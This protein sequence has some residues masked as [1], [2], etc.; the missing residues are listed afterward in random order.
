MLR[1]IRL[2]GEV[3]D[4]RI[5]RSGRK[6]VGLRICQQG[7]QVNAPHDLTSAQI[8]AIVLGKTDWIL[9]KL[10]IWRNK[11]SQD[12]A[13]GF[14]PGTAVFPLLGDLWKPEITVNGQL[15][16]VPADSAEKK[17]S[18]RYLSSEVF[19]KWMID[20][21]RQRALACFSERLALYADRLNLPYPPFKLSH[22]KTRWG[23]CN[24][25]GV[26]RLNVRLV[27]L[28]LFL[29]DYVVAHELCHLFEMNH[30]SAFWKRVAAIY[31]DYQHARRELR[32]Y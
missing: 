6:S 19:R 5:K 13:V 27:Q 7:L 8:D 12:T 25:S 17:L 32:N 29:V 18:D 21:Y 11:L 20:W 16:M 3:I 2:A 14:L 9:E 31:P 4:Y 15:C 23:S 28:P 26:I 30:S 10:V 22:A 24:S 1:Q